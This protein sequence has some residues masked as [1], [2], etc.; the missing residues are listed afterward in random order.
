[1]RRVCIFID[2]VFHKLLIRELSPIPGITQ[3]HR[4]E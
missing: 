2:Y 3:T 1:V 4:V